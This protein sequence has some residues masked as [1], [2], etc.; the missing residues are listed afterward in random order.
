[1]IT[2]ILICVC[3]YIVVAITPFALHVFF[4]ISGGIKQKKC[5]HEKY[6]ETMACHGKCRDCGKDLGFIGDLRETNASGEIR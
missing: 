5:S 3:L 6:H 2:F 1:M 4:A